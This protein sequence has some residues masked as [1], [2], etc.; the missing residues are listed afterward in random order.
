MLYTKTPSI[1]ALFDC[2]ELMAHP[3]I[4]TTWETL[5]PYEHR[6]H[7]AYMWS[8][9]SNLEFL[10]VFVRKLLSTIYRAHNMQL[11][12]HLEQ[13][14]FCACF[15]CTMLIMYSLIKGFNGWKFYTQMQFHLNTKSTDFTH[16]IL[17]VIE[18]K[19]KQ[20]QLQCA[21]LTVCWFAL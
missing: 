5:E 17:H 6:E 18:I 2:S 13:L 10:N 4:L 16:R 11:F 12:L 14:T 19:G 8:S 15:S 21:S 20:L 9:Q 1:F 7:T 3:V